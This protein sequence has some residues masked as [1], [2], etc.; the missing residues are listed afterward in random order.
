MD[1]HRGQEGSRKID[2]EF[3]AEEDM[4]RVTERGTQRDQVRRHQ[5]R[6]AAGQTHK[7]GEGTEEREREWNGEVKRETEAHREADRDTDEK[8]G[9]K[10]TCRDGGTE[11]QSGRETETDQR[12]TEVQQGERQKPRATHQQRQPSAFGNG[13]DGQLPGPTL[14]IAVKNLP[15]PSKAPPLSS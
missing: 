12:H 13:H 15:S 4:E 7:N 14:L 8:E 1:T 5:D 6:G 10:M 11:I 2:E 9:K 3:V